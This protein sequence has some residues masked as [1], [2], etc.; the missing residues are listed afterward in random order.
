MDLTNI[1]GNS[2]WYSKTPVH[3][4]SKRRIGLTAL[5]ASDEPQNYTV[6]NMWSN[7]VAKKERGIKMEEKNYKV[8]RFMW[9]KFTKDIS[10]L[11]IRCLWRVKQ[12]LGNNIC[13]CRSYHVVCKVRVKHVTMENE[14]FKRQRKGKENW[15]THIVR[16]HLKFIHKM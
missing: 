15:L 11:N 3:H 7:D 6:K 5:Y 1:S 10:R 2:V 16:P 12:L 13:V 9:N 4:I 14:G 8:F